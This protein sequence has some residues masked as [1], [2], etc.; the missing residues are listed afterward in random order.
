[1]SLKAIDMQ[2]LVPRSHDVGKIQQLQLQQ[3]QN[4]SHHT[5]VELR[6]DSNVQQTSVNKLEDTGKKIMDNNK[7]SN[8][9]GSKRRNNSSEP[10]EQE[11]KEEC[12]PKHLGNI[13]D[14]H[15]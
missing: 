4:Q 2:V 6:R 11:E 10:S 8:K 9:D 5:G 3:Q 13:L 14:I 15:I 7:E 12:S 1:M